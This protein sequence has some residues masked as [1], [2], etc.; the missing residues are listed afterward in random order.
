VNDEAK[1]TRQQGGD[2]TSA[3]GSAGT[4]S[5][6]LYRAAQQDSLSDAL[7]NPLELRYDCPTGLETAWH[8]NSKWVV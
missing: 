5:P 2:G 1:S 4:S 7:H 8:K 3:A 6:D